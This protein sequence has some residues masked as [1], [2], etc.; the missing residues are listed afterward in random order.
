MECIECD[1]ST[2][3]A[4][5]QT[6]LILMSTIAFLGL[7]IWSNLVDLKALSRFS[8]TDETSPMYI[9]KNKYVLNKVCQSIILKIFVNY[10]QILSISNSLN[11][12][13]P[14]EVSSFLK[15]QSSFGQLSDSLLSI[16]CLI[17]TDIG[18]PYVYFRSIL[19]CIF[20]FFVALIILGFWS[21][22]SLIIIVP[23]ITSMI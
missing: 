14:G 13:W 16:E 21:T 20:P 9:M 3:W 2:G 17:K 18:I 6:S 5:V 10:A 23:I 4:A 19:L 15:L 7:L 22:Y 11:I 1:T 12:R 8:L